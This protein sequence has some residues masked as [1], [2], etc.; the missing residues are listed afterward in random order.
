MYILIKIKEITIYLWNSYD[1]FFARTSRKHLKGVA[2]H[3][4]LYST[5]LILS[6]SYKKVSQREVVAEVTIRFNKFAFLALQN[7]L[8]HA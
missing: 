4:N 1:I 7:V 5:V 8:A 2:K 6:I 3:Y